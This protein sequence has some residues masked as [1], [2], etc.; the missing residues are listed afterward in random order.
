MLPKLRNVTKYLLSCLKCYWTIGWIQLNR[1]ILT[2]QPWCLN[3]ILYCINAYNIAVIQ[4]NRW[5]C[6]LIFR[7]LINMFFEQKPFK[8]FLVGKLLSFYRIQLTFGRPGITNTLLM[9]KS[10]HSLDPLQKHPIFLFWHKVGKLQ[11]IV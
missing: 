9:D 6:C 5:Y 1:C 10:N 7:N 3:V 4:Q 2:L 8:C 11:G